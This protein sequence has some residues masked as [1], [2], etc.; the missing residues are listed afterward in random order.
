MSKFVLKHAIYL[1]FL[2]IEE[3]SSL[4]WKLPGIYKKM[5]KSQD[6]WKITKNVKNGQ[7]SSKNW[8]LHEM[9]LRFSD[10]GE[11]SF[12]PTFDRRYRTLE[13]KNL[14]KKIASFL[15]KST[16]M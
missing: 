9:R 11:C 8:K 7:K 16:K 4:F 12:R 5:I 15:K 10:L 14:G 2:K 1:I 13:V 3:K 6:F